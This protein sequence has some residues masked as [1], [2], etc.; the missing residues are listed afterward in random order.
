MSDPGR[1]PATTLEDV[2]SVFNDRDDYAEPMTAPE[3]ADRLD[4]SRRTALNKLHALEDAGNV[5]SKK[6]GGRSK[7][8]WVPVLETPRVEDELTSDAVRH[9][10]TESTVDTPSIEDPID[11]LDS[12]TTALDTLDAADNRRAAVRACVEYLREHGTAQKSGFVEDVYPDYNAGYSS[13]G[14]WWNKIGK[15]YLKTVADECDSVEPPK[16]EGS[17][18]WQWV[19]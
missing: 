9:E 19:E 10:A 4:C 2:L 17:H 1:K 16:K 13:T 7:V 3:F 5:S 18:I 15:E 8:W 11:D 12:L 6:V 14:G